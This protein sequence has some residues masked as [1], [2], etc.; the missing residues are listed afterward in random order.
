MLFLQIRASMY[1]RDIHEELISNEV[2]IKEAKNTFKRNQFNDQKTSLRLISDLRQ[3]DTSFF[4]K[5]YSSFRENCSYHL[6]L[7]TYNKRIRTILWTALENIL[8]W[9]GFLGAWRFGFDIQR[10]IY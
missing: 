1:S 2:R 5:R 6:S 7:K 3:D 4:Q 8:K 10:G 9:S